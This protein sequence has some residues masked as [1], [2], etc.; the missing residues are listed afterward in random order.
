MAARKE[1]ER[2]NMVETLKS[3]KTQRVSIAQHW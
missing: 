1:E 3:L 2:P